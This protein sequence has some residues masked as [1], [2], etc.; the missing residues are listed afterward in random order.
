MEGPHN[1]TNR[2]E[3]RQA[4]LRRYT[5]HRKGHTSKQCPSKALFCRNRSELRNTVEDIKLRQGV[6]NGFL[7]D[8]LLLVYTG[9][10]KTIVRRDL[11]EEEWWLEGELTFASF[12]AI[13]LVP[14][15][16]SLSQTLISSGNILIDC[17]IT[18][19]SINFVLVSQSLSHFAAI[20]VRQVT[21]YLDG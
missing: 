3:S 9:C 12:P 7:V 16:C 15:S 20:S 10:S 2:E 18:I 6:V 4:M 17:S 5:S 8:D 11:V 21:M 1:S 14:G 13:I 19:M